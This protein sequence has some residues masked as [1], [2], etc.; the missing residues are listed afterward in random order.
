MSTVKI[1]IFCCVDK[2]NLS[3]PR[4]VHEVHIVEDDP[5]VECWIIVLQSVHMTH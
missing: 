2:V 5:E 1:P 3:L 4:S